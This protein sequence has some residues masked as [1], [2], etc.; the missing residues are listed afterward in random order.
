MPPFDF[1]SA[2]QS[3]LCQQ[4]R[5]DDLR[6]RGKDLPFARLVNPCA[7]KPFQPR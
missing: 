7:K 6:G 1:A 5:S 3:H 4:V 2:F